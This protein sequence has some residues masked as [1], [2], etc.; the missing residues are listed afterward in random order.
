VSFTV[1]AVSIPSSSAPDTVPSDGVAAQWRIV[2]HCVRPGCGVIAAATL[3]FDYAQR[4]VALDPMGRRAIPGEY[5]LCEQHAART[6]PPSGWTMRDRAPSRVAETESA[7]PVGP[8]RA[9]HVGRLAAALS[10]VP[11]TVSED[12]PDAVPVGTDRSV[13]HPGLAPARAHDGSAAQ[14]RSAPV[15]TTAA[16]RGPARLD[17]LMGGGRNEPVDAA[18][19][20]ADV[21]GGFARERAPRDAADEAF[22]HAR[23]LR[24][25]PDPIA[26]A[27]CA[28]LMTPGA[29]PLPVQSFVAPS[30][31]TPLGRPGGPPTLFG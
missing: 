29:R 4:V 5:D 31:I 10:A 30:G 18:D 12:V 26:S 24:L 8:E 17:A 21:R 14:V 13:P 19:H 11:R 20:G 15:P 28:D 2:R 23:A 16:P 22:P 27:W 25:A 1:S 7:P 3:R 6:T 9:S